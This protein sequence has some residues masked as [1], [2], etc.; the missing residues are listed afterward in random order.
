MALMRL[1]PASLFRVVPNTPR[2]FTQAIYRQPTFRNNNMHA[3]DCFHT[4]LEML[5]K[6][7]VW[8][9]YQRLANLEGAALAHGSRRIQYQ[10]SHQS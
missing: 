4:Q 9:P 7:G 8:L 1:E 5:S 2:S 6:S 10:G 3:Y